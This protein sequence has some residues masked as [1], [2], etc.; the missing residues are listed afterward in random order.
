MGLI[1]TDRWHSPGGGKEMLRLAWPLILS[2][3]FWT[4]Q[5]ILDRVLLS[6]TNSDA[7][8]AAVAAAM[9]FWA[10]M[11][12]LQY[13]AN[14]A[15]T[16]V[17]Q[18][19]GAQKP[20]RVGPAVWQALWFSVLTG[21]GFLGLI[22]LA[23]PLIALGGH[24]PHLQVM[25]EQYFR[26]LTFAALPMLVNAA[27]S[28]FFVGRGDSRTVLFISAVGLTVNALAAYAWIFGRWGF[29][30]WGIVGAGRATVLG[31][32]ASAILAVG[33][34]LRAP[35][36]KAYGTASGWRF[37]T[38]LFR[39]LLYYG[40]PNGL[41]AAL[42]VLGY[43]IFLFLIGRLGAAEI[44]ASSV[45]FTINAVVFLPML[46]LGQ[47][48]EVL[49]GQR[50]GEDRPDLAERSTWTGCRVAVLITGLALLGYLS[51]PHTLA[52]F[53][54][55]E[56]AASEGERVAELVPVLLRFVAVYSLFDN[57]N[58]VFSYA[59]RGAGDTRFVT[60]VAVALAWPV[61]VLPTW[62][63]W[64]F[65]WGLWWAWSFAT[66]YIIL[67]AATFWLRFRQGKWRHMRV[68]ETASTRKEGP[69][70]GTGGEAAILHFQSDDGR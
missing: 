54:H 46:G 5:I 30:A 6:Q 32:S 62:A 14:Y 44:T 10:P 64:H 56:D 15:T 27:A 57:L 33:L 47:A 51:I 34:M 55:A 11:C 16:F 59:L 35:Y 43:T 37:D 70:E 21:V 28:S 40:L 66:L 17:A 52:G 26:C 68:I 36:R 8:G 25:E 69:V 50:L 45:A 12:L 20:H 4:L 9:L 38:D 18:Y 3:S 13:T 63:A 29:P 42:D 31:S 58:A 41:M 49:V 22:P 48:V 7:V 61:M 67:L 1:S 53:F 39:R 60:A 65:G 2:N 24:A 19:T 23:G